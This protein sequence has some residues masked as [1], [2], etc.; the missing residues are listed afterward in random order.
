MTSQKKTETNYQIYLFALF[1]VS[2]FCGIT[3]LVFNR[4]TYNMWFLGLQSGQWS[5]W[6]SWKISMA[7]LSDYWKWKPGRM[8]LLS[9][10][11]AWVVTLVSGAWLVVTAV[12]SKSKSG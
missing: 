6:P 3:L 4:T 11:S 7:E 8:L 12:L 1:S 10:L 2:L 9:C 5:F